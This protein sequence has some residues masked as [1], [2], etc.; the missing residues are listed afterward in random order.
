MATTW[1]KAL[2]RSGGSIAVAL[3]RSTDYIKD[4][5]KTN[6]GE[7]LDSFECDPYTAQ[8][9]F[10]FSK[11][12]Y[13]QR[14]GRDQGRNDVIAYHVRMSFKPGEVT[15]EQALELGRELAL[16]WTKRR[17]QFIVAAHTNTN[18]PHIHIIYNSVNLDCTGKYQDFKR[19]AIA[20]RR[21]SDMI[22]VEHGLSVIEKPGLSKGYNRNEYLGETKPPTVRD[23]LRELMDSVIPACKNYDGFLAALEV[24]GVEIKC[25]KQLSFRL[26]DGKKF[27]RQDTLGDDY[28]VEAILERISGKRIV[29]PKQKPIEIQKP[30]E[31][32]LLIDIERK[33]K[34]GYGAGFERYARIKNLKDMAKTLIYLQ[35]NNLADYDL[36]VKTADDSKKYYNGI[37]DK[38]KG[39]ESR[40]KEITELQKQISN[41]SRTL[42][43]YRGYRDS[44]W[45]KKY[46][47]EHESEIMIHKAAKKHFESVGLEK[48]PRME[49]LKQEYAKLSAENKKIYPEQKVAREKMIELLMAKQNVNMILGEPHQP[50]KSHERDSL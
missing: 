6:D 30:R 9:E 48:L 47:A 40:M 50:S 17:H 15:A 49:S 36:L 33:M 2:H 20:L 45:S 41:Y 21:V 13:E 46:Y 10:L 7:L 37:S 19:S 38:T 3:D 32:N 24:A 29:E 42:D 18:N 43:A 5:N 14:T 34:Q 23:Q 4:G 11:R 35:D 8:S 26:P 39:N 12:L 1:I 22:C 16:R 31:F 28:T 25:G 44:K 27:S